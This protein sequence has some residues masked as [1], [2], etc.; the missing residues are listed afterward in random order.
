MDN[1]SP[2]PKKK[3]NPVLATQPINQDVMDLVANKG[4]PKSSPEIQQVKD[5]LLKIIQTSGADPQKI[6]TAAKYARQAV[7]K[8]EM[9]PMA[10]EIAIKSGILTPDQAPKGEGIDYQL[11]ANGITAGKLTEELIKEGKL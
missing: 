8:P 1:T 5:R 2:S 3:E 4:Q 11:L 7:Q 10:I 9:Y 6:I